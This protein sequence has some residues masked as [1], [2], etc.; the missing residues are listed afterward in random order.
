M[1]DELTVRNLGV[2]KE[3]TIYPTPGLTVITG[4]TGTGKTLLLG[5]VRL[6]LGAE[7]RPDLVGPFGEEASVEGRFVDGDRELV[8][9]R[10]LQR[11]G[12][13]RAY[14]DGS[15]ASTRAL[16]ATLDG[17]EI[18]GQHDQL[19]LTRSAEV[20]AMIDSKLERPGRALLDRYR[21]SRTRWERLSADRDR[22]GGDRRALARELD[23]ASFQAAEIAQAA[24]VPGD[25]QELEVRA[26]RLR[27]AEVLTQYLNGARHE[28]ESGTDSLGGAVADLRRA[29]RL[30]PGLTSIVEAAEMASENLSELGRRL[31]LASEQVVADPDEQAMVE[32]RLTVLGD[33]RRK[34][35]SDLEEVLGF[36]KA[37]AVRASELTGLLE[38]AATIDSD[39]ETSR[40]GLLETARL[41]TAARKKAG[42]GLMNA[43][44]KHLGELGFTD[45]V[46]AVEMIPAE[47]GPWGGDEVR[48][49]FA[50][51]SRLAPGEVGRVASGGE[52]SRLVLSLRLAAAQGS[53]SSVLVFDEIDAGIGGATALAMGRKLAA[54]SRDHQVLCVTHLPQ[55]AAFAETHYVIER[56][57]VTAAVRMVEGADRTIQLAQMLAGLPDSERGREAAA[58]L[59]ALAQQGS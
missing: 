2:I 12:R 45:P 10:R 33:L 31:R 57:G 50:S 59:L 34:Y 32:A 39:L 16:A 9:A 56:E 24:F 3:A 6:L 13:S 41:L 25:D 58:E 53:G 40:Q 23:L 44:V 8:V 15:I 5:A 51:D 30:D 47:L 49:V 26:N 21:E 22:L 28:V 20:R 38:Q 54:L 35:G 52:L 7:G 1:L 46:L 42:A 37:A 18:I 27:H 17:I 48:L 4:E 43:A 36:G 11:E 55:V 14:L 19:S 29:A